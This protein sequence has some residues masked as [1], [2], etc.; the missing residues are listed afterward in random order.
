MALAKSGT[1]QRSASAGSTGAA[2]RRAAELPR[3]TRVLR[4]RAVDPLGDAAHRTREQR[5]HGDLHHARARA[6]GGRRF[7]HATGAKLGLFLVEQVVDLAA[8]ADAKRRLKKQQ[9]Q[10]GGAD[11]AG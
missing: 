1:L 11:D 5:H 10:A 4:T 6:S 9:D 2:A 7:A 3:L 8:D